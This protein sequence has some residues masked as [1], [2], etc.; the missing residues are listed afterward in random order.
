MVDLSSQDEKSFV[1]PFCG[2]EMER[3][4]KRCE[5]CASILDMSEENNDSDNFLVEDEPEKAV[6]ED[7]PTVNQKEELNIE[8]T[9]FE[10]ESNESNVEKQP[11]NYQTFNTEYTSNI[12]LPPA[13][14][15]LTNADKVL[16]TTVFVMIPVIG[17]FIGLIRAIMFM[18]SGEE[19]KDCE[20]RRS[21][22][23]ALLLACVIAFVITCFSGFALLVIAAR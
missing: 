4:S 16:L 13:R 1:C 12:L 9:H 22:G 18:N 2:Y 10:S 20:D 17:Q 15:P 19:L 8:N 6:S 23:L 3:K 21:F 7:T 5:N 14:R 11:L